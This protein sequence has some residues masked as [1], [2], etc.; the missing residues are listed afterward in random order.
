MEGNYTKVVRLFELFAHF[1]KNPNLRL[2]E[3]FSFVSISSLVCEVNKSNTLCGHTSLQNP[4]MHVYNIKTS[5]S[6][7]SFKHVT[8]GNAQLRASEI[9]E[10]RGSCLI[11]QD[12]RGVQLRGCQYY[13]LNTMTMQ[14]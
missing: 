11:T 2:L 7:T 4:L 3:F 12:I 5:N 13:L 6:F 9:P 14:F 10:D 1:V 8:M